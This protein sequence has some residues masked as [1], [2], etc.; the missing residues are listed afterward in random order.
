MAYIVEER[1]RQDGRAVFAGDFFAGDLRQ[2][3]QES[4]GVVHHA[5]GM[6]ETTVVRCRKNQLA[7]SELF[8]AAEPLKFAAC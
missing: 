6:S 4:A 5:D 1:R 8:N 3:T 7:H 2:A